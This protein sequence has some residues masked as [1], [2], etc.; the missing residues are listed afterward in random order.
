MAGSDY[1]IARSLPGSSTGYEQSPGQTTAGDGSEDLESVAVQE[2][3]G[4]RDLY[5]SLYDAD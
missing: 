5:R 2:V 3:A 1:L 4:N